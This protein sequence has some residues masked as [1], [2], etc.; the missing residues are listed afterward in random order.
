[1]VNLKENQKG[2]QVYYRYIR[3]IMKSMTSINLNYNTLIYINDIK[4]L[5]CN[6]NELNR[7]LAYQYLLKTKITLKDF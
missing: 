3:R 7:K 4:Y 2:N 6:I 5:P 1:M